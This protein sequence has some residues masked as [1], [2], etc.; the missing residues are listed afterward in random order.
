M[1]A[2][3]SFLAFSMSMMGMSSLI[4]YMSWQCW[5]IKPLPCSL[6]LTSPLHWGQAKISNSSLLIAITTL[7]PDELVDWQDR[8]PH[9]CYQNYNDF[10]KYFLILGKAELYSQ[11][12][13]FCHSLFKKS[14]TRDLIY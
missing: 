6:S 2:Y 4:S 14:R 11:L 8:R 1:A 12:L 10:Q 13:H 5:Q 7:R 9:P 3:E